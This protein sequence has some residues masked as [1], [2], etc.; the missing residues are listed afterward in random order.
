MKHNFREL[1]IW[2]DSMQLVKSIYALTYKMPDNEKYGL[3]SQIQRCAVSIPSNIAEGTGRGGDKELNYFLNI[4]LSS[5]Y[6]LE[7]QLI[8]ISELYNLNIAVELE[9]LQK[10]IGGFKR[11]LKSLEN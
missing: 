3:I 5:S 2:K 7:T 11:S 9:Q 6:E 8:L 10:M 1:M 4:G